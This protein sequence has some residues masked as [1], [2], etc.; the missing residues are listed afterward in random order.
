MKDTRLSSDPGPLPCGVS[1]LSIRRIKPG[2]SFFVYQRKPEGQRGYSSVFPLAK[3]SS[4]GVHRRIL[5]LPY[6]VPLWGY[7]LLSASSPAAL[8]CV[9]C[10][11]PGERRRKTQVGYAASYKHHPTL[12]STLLRPKGAK[13][14]DSKYR[15][16][17][18][19]RPR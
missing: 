15:P 11:L 8:F 3:L 10:P 14:P 16:I 13:D 1:I 5:P 7:P 17:A 12:P 19:L 6:F 18:I 9:A 2:T 4:P